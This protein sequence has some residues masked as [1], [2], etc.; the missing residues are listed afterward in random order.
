MQACCMRGY[1]KAKHALSGSQYSSQGFACD[2]DL[3]AVP[4]EAWSMIMIYTDNM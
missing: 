1:N 2:S 3:S 4:G